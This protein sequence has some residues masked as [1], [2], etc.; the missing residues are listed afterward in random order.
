MCLYNSAIKEKYIIIIIITNSRSQSDNKCGGLDWSWRTA[1]CQAFEHSFKRKG[2]H[3]QNI[4][5]ILSNLQ[6]NPWAFH[7]PL[8]LGM[9]SVSVPR[10]WC[11]CS[12]AG[13]WINVS[14]TVGWIII[15]FCFSGLIVTYT[16]THIYLYIRDGIKA[17]SSQTKGL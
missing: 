7:Y 11:A 3:L 16:N 2:N 13:F 14:W 1:W 9:I 4:L 8:P 17:G 12:T 10:W 15:E 5:L 6:L